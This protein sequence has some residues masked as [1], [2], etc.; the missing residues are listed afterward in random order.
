MSHF[1]DYM[2]RQLDNLNSLNKKIAQARE[3]CHPLQI[4]IFETNGW[5]VYIT[6]YGEKLLYSVISPTGEITIFTRLHLLSKKVISGDLYG[7]GVR[8]FLHTKK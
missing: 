3:A 7:T 2:Y 4:H 5:N 6:Y 8:T 1:L